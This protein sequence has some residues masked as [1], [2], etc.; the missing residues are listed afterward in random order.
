MS[1][2]IIIS[3][4]PPSELLTFLDILADILASSYLDRSLLNATSDHLNGNSI[5]EID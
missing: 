5:L 1:K 3:L 4:H 2:K